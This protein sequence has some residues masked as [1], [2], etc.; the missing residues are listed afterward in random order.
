MTNERKVIGGDVDA[1]TVP[2]KATL[3]GDMPVKRQPFGALVEDET[4][5][6]TE[7]GG[8]KPKQPDGRIDEGATDKRENRPR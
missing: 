3:S 8:V 5:A 6:G 4:L 7:Q 2:A 1:R